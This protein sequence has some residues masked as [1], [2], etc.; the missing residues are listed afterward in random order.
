M[1]K[2][3]AVLAYLSILFFISSPDS[4]ALSAANCPG[5]NVGF[6]IKELTSNSSDVTLCTDVIIPPSYLFPSSSEFGSG[7]YP[8]AINTGCRRRFRPMCW[9]FSPL[10]IINGGVNKDPQAETVTLASNFSF[11]VMLLFV[12]FAITP[13]HFILLPETPLV[14]FSSINLSALHPV[15]ITAP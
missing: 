1:E 2:R 10:A 8:H 11:L 7:K 4:H 3:W 13:K 9:F 15:T 12:L 6:S 14:F 5:P